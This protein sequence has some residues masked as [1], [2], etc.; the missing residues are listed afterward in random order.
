MALCDVSATTVKGVTT[1][2]D[3]EVGFTKFPS[4]LLAVYY[5]SMSPF[6]L[7]FL[8]SVLYFNFHRS[9]HRFR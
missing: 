4:L 7:Y 2:G 5:R 3:L 9:L 8:Y 1:A 6:F